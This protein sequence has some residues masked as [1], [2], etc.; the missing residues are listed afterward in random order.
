MPMHRIVY[1]PLAR[2]D[3][4]N[5]AL[6]I[7]DTLKAPKAALDLLESI[8]RAIERLGRFP[9]SCKVY[10]PE[11]VLNDEYRMLIVKNYAIFY[12]ATEDTVE[13]RRIIYAKRDLS[14]IIK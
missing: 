10:K 7:A 13:I 6:Y 1:L 11:H 5:V 14:E 8:E 4:S 3:L 9:Y 2:E 12:V